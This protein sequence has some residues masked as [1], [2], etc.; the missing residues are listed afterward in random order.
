MN[1]PVKHVCVQYILLLV[2]I[3]VKTNDL[4]LKKI[5]EE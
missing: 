3:F 1:K 4:L 2:P 5:L